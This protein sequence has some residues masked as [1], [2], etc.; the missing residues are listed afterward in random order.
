MHSP[1][2]FRVSIVHFGVWRA[3]CAGLSAAAVL[4][5][6]LWAAAMVD[7]TAWVWL[8]PLAVSAGCALLLRRPVPFHLRWDTQD[9]FVEPG[10]GRVRA[11]PGVLQVALDL[12]GWMLLRFA[13]TGGGRDRWLPVQRRGHE[14]AWHGLRSTVY[15]ARPPVDRAVADL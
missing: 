4:T 10:T 1:P 12:G 3:L 9:W 2:A 8:W 15:C 11:Q 7:H 13:P 6:V 5:A 14:P